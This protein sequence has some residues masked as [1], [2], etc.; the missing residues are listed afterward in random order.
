MSQQDQRQVVRQDLSLY[1]FKEKFMGRV[2]PV[3]KSFKSLIP[4]KI[5]EQKPLDEYDCPI[6]GKK[7][8]EIVCSNCRDYHAPLQCEGEGCKICAEIKYLKE[9][10]K[11]KLTKEKGQ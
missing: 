9:N 7:R 5:I 11:F 10:K 4:R 2:L 1:Y 3:T 6:C 8:T